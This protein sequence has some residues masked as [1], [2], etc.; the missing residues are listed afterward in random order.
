MSHYHLFLSGKVGWNE[1]CLEKHLRYKLFCNKVVTEARARVCVN[2][3]P[4]TEAGAAIIILRVGTIKKSRV[5][6]HEGDSPL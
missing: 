1:P 6:K 4:L 5:E 3:L 2:F